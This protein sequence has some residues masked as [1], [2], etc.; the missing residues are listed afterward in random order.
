MGDSSD[1]N[2][3]RAVDF[4]ET[5]E[6]TQVSPEPDKSQT[7]IIEAAPISGDHNS[8]DISTILNRK[9]QEEHTNTNTEEIKKIKQELHDI[10]LESEAPTYNSHF[11]AEPPSPQFKVENLTRE[12][13]LDKTLQELAV[14]GYEPNRD[15]KPFKNYGVGGSEL[16]QVQPDR[17]YIAKC[18][19]TED[20]EN[21][22]EDLVVKISMPDQITRESVRNEVK[23]SRLLDNLVHQYIQSGEGLTVDFPHVVDEF[24]TNLGQEAMVSE[25][26]NDD[27]EYKLSL[28]PEQMTHTLIQTAKE[29]HKLP[30]ENLI[31]EADSGISIYD[32]SRIREDLE[33]QTEN[34]PTEFISPEM[35]EEISHILEENLS[36]LS[37]YSLHLAHGDLHPMNLAITKDHA[38]GKPHVVV[39]DV[40]AL[41]VSNRFFDAAKIV[42][43]VD[44]YQQV[45]AGKTDLDASVTEAA[46]SVMEMIN[47]SRL[48]SQVEDAFVM[49]EQ[50]RRIFGLMR[51]AD[52]VSQLY[53]VR[54]KTD[55]ISE[56][57]S[58]VLYPVQLENILQ[59]YFRTS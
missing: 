21:A 4:F 38:T 44:L 28:G 24:Q 19:R 43:R 8:Q 52:V 14:K 2:F 48:K 11:D 1:P 29:L 6:T 56:K 30:I 59:E 17:F 41:R 46:K 47:Y 18:H 36:L 26:V 15:V 27:K 32:A 51:V 40:E 37:E 54:D 55:Q 20:N 22:Q 13:I 49:S 39:M 45:L 33:W 25:Y 3:P 12:Q 35:K 42:N 50:D 31:K 23:M 53:N 58:K 7:T 57:V 34:M 10:Q 9:S 16:S 5:T